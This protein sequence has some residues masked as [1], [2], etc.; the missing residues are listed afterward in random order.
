MNLFDLHCDTATVL[1]QKNL[2]FKNSQTHINYR[3]LEGHRVTQCFAVFFSDKAK[4]FPGKDFFSAVADTVFPQLRRPGLTP[5]LTAEGVGVMAEETGWI[6]LLLS[7]NCRMASLVWNGTNSLATGAV[8]DNRAPLTDAGKEAAKE[9]EE[10]GIVLDVSHL[11]DKGTEDLLSLTRRPIVASHSNAREV[12]PHVRNLP[13]EL[14]TEIFHRGGLVGLNLYPPF[15]SSAGNAVTEDI[16]RHAE[17]FLALGGEQGLA[18]GCDLDG[19]EALPAGI[20]H[21]GDLPLLHRQFCNAFGE[22]TAN[23]IFHN[24]AA[25]FFGLE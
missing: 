2:P 4:P 23:N 10:R 16:L 20:R 18:L 19:V 6:D 12:T 1:Y 9:L 24:N 11:S 14:A 7:K 21:L 13:D 3:N 15:L 22:T 25:R 8:T 17:H 5:M